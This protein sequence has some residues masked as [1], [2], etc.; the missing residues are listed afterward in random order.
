VFVG[1]GLA[2]PWCW[3]GRGLDLLWQRAVRPCLPALAANSVI[4]ACVFL[5][6]DAL[7]RAALAARSARRRTDA[8]A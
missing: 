1:P 5:A 7:L 8:D 4:A 3:T 6:G 2:R